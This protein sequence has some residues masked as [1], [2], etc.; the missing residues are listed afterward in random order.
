MALLAEGLLF[1]LCLLLFVEDVIISKMSDV[2]IPRAVPLPEVG[3]HT[4]DVV[5]GNLGLPVGFDDE[6]ILVNLRC[7]NRVRAVAG[8]GSVSVI[9]EKG[10]TSSYDYN[11]TSMDSGAATFGAVSKQNKTPASSGS[12]TFP[13]PSTL[14]GKADTTIAINNSEIEER[15]RTKHGT[16]GL[17]EPVP[18]AREL[19]AAVKTGLAH[20]AIDA[21]IDKGKLKMAVRLYGIMGAFGIAAGA[22]PGRALLIPA[23]MG[24]M[25]LNLHVLRESS[26]YQ[27][28]PFPIWRELRQ[29]L[30]V[31]PALDRVVV[32]NGILKCSRL[33][34]ARS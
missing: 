13:T 9:G 6:R 7:I 28:N 2:K 21:N 16:I 25:F 33:M 31:G 3:K 11:V 26:M 34:K 22:S 24:P 1:C 12:V 19:N 8:L 30:L 18:R 29:S 27:K 17:Y 32:A 15:L 20:A 5:F 14:F 23:V 10:D 4:D